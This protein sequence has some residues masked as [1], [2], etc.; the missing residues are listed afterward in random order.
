MPRRIARTRHGRRD[1]EDQRRGRDGLGVRK[2]P[3]ASPSAPIVWKSAM[4][5]VTPITTSP[6]P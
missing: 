3:L 1:D 6:R 2:S 4:I 5:A